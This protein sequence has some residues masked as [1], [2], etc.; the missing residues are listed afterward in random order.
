MFIGLKKDL[1][2]GQK[3]PVTLTFK[4]GSTKTINPEVKKIDTSH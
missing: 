1:D 3:V 2:L 4:D